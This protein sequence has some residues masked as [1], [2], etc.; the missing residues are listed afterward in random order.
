MAIINGAY[1]SFLKAKNVSAA[2]V[3]IF[4]VM[5]FG[6]KNYKTRKNEREIMMNKDN[7]HC[8]YCGGSLTTNTSKSK[9]HI[10][11]ICEKCGKWQ[12]WISKREYA[13]LRLQSDIC[14]R[15]DA[16]LVL[17]EPINEENLSETANTYEAPNTETKVTKP[18]LKAHVPFKD[19]KTIKRS[20]RADG[21]VR[22]KCDVTEK[23]LD[24][25]KEIV[26]DFGRCLDVSK[27]SKAMANVYIAL[28]R[29]EYVYHNSEEIQ[30]YINNMIEDLRKR[31]AEKSIGLQ[32][33]D[34]AKKRLI[35][36]GYDVKNGA[37][38]LRREIEDELESIL[39][40]NILSNKLD[41]GDIA[42]V[43]SKKDQF[44]LTKVKE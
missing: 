15:D 27:I 38:P 21:Q 34:A 41:K 13:E 36:K 7:L 26:F 43:D 33:T 16:D 8:K 42:K 11:L 31:L 40:D 2:I 24:L 22:T 17:S 18:I 37:R 10:A 20:V 4:G 30:G 25:C 19:G 44:V 1:D 39:A 14:K 6:G 29:L 3:S 12:K 28:R 32:L 9:A 5:F 23:L 35:E